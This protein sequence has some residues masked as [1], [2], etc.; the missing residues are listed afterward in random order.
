MRGEWRAVLAL[1]SAPAFHFFQF[2]GDFTVEKVCWHCKVATTIKST[3]AGGCT[4]KFV[5]EVNLSPSCE[6]LA[7]RL[8]A[9]LIGN[10]PSVDCREG[11]FG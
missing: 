2:S 1:G 10:W 7:E 8:F 4:G 5:L 6:S 9:D 11:S 3:T